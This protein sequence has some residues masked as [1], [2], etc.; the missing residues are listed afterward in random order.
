MRIVIAF[1]VGLLLLTGCKK[2]N[3]DD[4]G[5]VLDKILS[6][7]SSD[8]LFEVSYTT[9][10]LTLIDPIGPT[11]P[12]IDKMV[13]RPTETKDLVKL[14]VWS[15][16]HYKIETEKLEADIPSFT[17]IGGLPNP[18]PVGVNTKWENNVIEI[19]SQ[20]GMLLNQEAQNQPDISNVVSEM[21]EF[22]DT[23]PQDD[24]GSITGIPANLQVGDD[25]E[26]QNYINDPKARISSQPNGLSSIHVD[27]AG[28]D[29]M[30]PTSAVVIFHESGGLKK[31]DAVQIYDQ[32][33]GKPIS[34]TVYKYG[35]TTN[36]F[37]PILGYENRTIIDIGGNTEVE[38]TSI[39]SFENFELKISF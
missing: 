17:V 9:T 20:N 39:V 35:E 15:A 3:L 13:E 28:E 27:L 18:N 32:T 5:G 19:R 34:S 37:I 21:I 36:N 6:L 11:T 22:I 23:Y 16:D 24:I 30:N 33:S 26:W 38:L 14:T 12:Q 2:D 1:T 31:F 8:P 7:T 4:S 10:V 29:G 25:S